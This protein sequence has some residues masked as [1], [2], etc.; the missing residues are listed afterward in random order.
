LSRIWHI[1]TEVEA[2]FG[3]LAE[4]LFSG[5][6]LEAQPQKPAVI[7]A[8]NTTDIIFFIIYYHAFF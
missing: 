2:I 5:T 4:P 3:L 1:A 6:P 7:I 8:D